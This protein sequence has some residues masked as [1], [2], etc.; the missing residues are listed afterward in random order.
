MRGFLRR[1]H[2]ALICISCGDEDAQLVEDLAEL[3]PLPRRCQRCGGSMLAT[4]IAIRWIIDKSI[5]LDWSA[6]APKRGRPLK[7]RVVA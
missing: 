1:L 4:E 7:Q 6:D 5:V 3:G 2:V